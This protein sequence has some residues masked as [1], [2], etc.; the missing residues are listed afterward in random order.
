MNNVY[1]VFAEFFYWKETENAKN[2]EC[3][4]LGNSIP[5]KMSVFQPPRSKT[6]EED[7]FLVAKVQFLSGG[8]GNTL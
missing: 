4:G 7:A 6:V 8:G 1:F 3:D 5:Y 2:H